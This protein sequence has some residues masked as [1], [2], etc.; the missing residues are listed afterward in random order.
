MQTP[1][2]LEKLDWV[3]TSNSWTTSYPETTVTGLIREP[4]DHCPCLVSVQAAIPK[5]KMFR[6]K[7]YLLDCEGFNEIVQDCWSRY[8]PQQDTAKLITAKFKNLR[9]KIREW[10]AS[11]SSLKTN[12]TNVKLCIQLL[13]TL[14][15]YRYLSLHEWNFR[16]ILNDKL[17][18]LLK[19]QKTY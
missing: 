5:G 3:F 15:E 7:I 10:Q 11:L 18:V 1:P 2:M 4:S 8:Y 16:V 17:V 12:I 19:H 13:E 9:S 14:E 6:F